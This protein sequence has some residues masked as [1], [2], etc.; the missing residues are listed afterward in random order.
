M[1]P[2]GV[3]ADFETQ[4]HSITVAVCPITAVSHHNIFWNFS[5]PCGYYRGNC[6]ITTVAVTLSFYSLDRAQ[7]K[8]T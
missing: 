7:V 6:G 2:L 8:N 1:N 3:T 5:H 4:H